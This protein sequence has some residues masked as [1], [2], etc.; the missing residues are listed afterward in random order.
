MSIEPKKNKGNI[1]NDAII[2]DIAEIVYM[3]RHEL[4]ER[5][6]ELLLQDFTRST[7]AAT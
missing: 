2:K 6:K 7:S 1:I 5:L 3:F 4:S